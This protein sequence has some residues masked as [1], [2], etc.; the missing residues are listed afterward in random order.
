M[1]AQVYS[2][3]WGEANPSSLKRSKVYMSVSVECK[4]EYEYVSIES[5]YEY[6]HEYVPS[7]F[8]CG[9]GSKGAV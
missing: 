9:Y 6:K 1:V 4:C 5:E 7:V 3:H 2:G 8:D